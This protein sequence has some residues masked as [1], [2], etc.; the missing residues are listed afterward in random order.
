MLRS[1]FDAVT[2]IP[3]IIEFYD[4]L[5]GDIQN[6]E[7]EKKFHFETPID[8]VSN[9]F[10]SSTSKFQSFFKILKS[11]NEIGKQLLEVLEIPVSNEKFV[12]IF[13]HH[14]GSKFTFSQTNHLAVPVKSFVSH[15]FQFSQIELI[16]FIMYH[17][18]NKQYF[19]HQYQTYDVGIVNDNCYTFVERF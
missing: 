17:F 4:N 18:I 11:N 7:F 2:N 10:A 5:F 13:H 3:T 15:V 16:M 14:D 19:V 12:V 1:I 8:P 9:T 6:S